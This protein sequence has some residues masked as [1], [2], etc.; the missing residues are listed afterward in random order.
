MDYKYIEQLLERYW[1]CSTTLE[2]E[3]ILRAFFSQDDVP[4]NLS[5]YRDLFVYEQKES[6]NNRLGD[7][8]DKKV[9]A[10]IN[11]KKTVD[12]R[13]SESSQG[14][15][16]RARRMSLTLRLRPLYKAVAIVAVLLTIGNAIQ[17]AVDNSRANPALVKTNG[18]A[19]GE[20]VAQTDTITADTV[21]QTRLAPA[22]ITDIS[23]P[24]AEAA[25]VDARQ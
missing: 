13:A 23:Q 22:E 17:T 3:A 16:V 2:E 21:K 8:F 14:S 25:P 19:G 9:L 24:A 11:G 4:E 10:K 1:E 18:L 7:D 15:T 5:A 20:Q 12:A 6:A